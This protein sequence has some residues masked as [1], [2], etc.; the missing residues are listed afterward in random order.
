MGGHAHRVGSPT[1]VRADRHLPRPGAWVLVFL[2]LT[3][4]IAFL[5]PELA[6]SER[7]AC[8]GGRPCASRL[9]SYGGAVEWL[10]TRR[11]LIVPAFV[12]DEGPGPTTAEGQRDGWSAFIL[13]LVAYSGVAWSV[14]SYVKVKDQVMEVR[15]SRLAQAV[16]PLSRILILT[17]TDLERDKVIAAVATAVPLPVPLR[18]KFQ[19]HHTVWPL[20][21]FGRAAIL[22]A[23]SGSGTL[24]PGSMMLT[25]RSLIKDVRPTY[26]VLT[27]ACVGLKPNKHAVGDVLVSTQLSLVDARH[28]V[29]QPSGGYREIPRGD[30]P[31]PSPTLLDRCRTA[32]FGWTVATV[33][34]GPFLSS[35]SEMVSRVAQRRL[36]DVDPDAIAYETEGAGAYAAATL[37]KV[38]WIIVKGVS[39]VGDGTPAEAMAQAISNAAEFVVH[40]ITEGGL[41]PPPW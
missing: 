24:N 30:R 33:D 34:F 29:D 6:A 31:S 21:V 26:L 9:V 40:V 39:D 10:L 23:Q 3:Y 12:P 25:A 11:F 35:N 1:P 5:A 36:T 15:R 20:G 19:Q 16:E 17:V 18:P 27:G 41:G 4:V 38:D 13:G 2:G 7:S 8:D 32:T 14:R 37:D 28:I 22:L